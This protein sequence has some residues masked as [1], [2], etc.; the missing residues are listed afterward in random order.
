MRKKPEKLR[1][2][3]EEIKFFIEQKR[4][5]QSKHAIQRQDE[6]KIG[7][8]DALHV[9]KTGR[10]EKNKTYFDRDFNTWKYAIRGYTLENFDIRV[11]VALDEDGMFIITVMHVD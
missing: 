4:F 7:L 9:L 5:K 11:I 1:N 2:L 6:R 10:E 3:L 8:L